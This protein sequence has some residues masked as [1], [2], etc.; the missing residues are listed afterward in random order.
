MIDSVCPILQRAHTIY[1]ATHISPDGDAIGSALGLALALGVLGKRCTVACADPAPA[2]VSFLPGS[3]MIVPQSPTTQDVIV[4]VDTG[5]TGRLG[6]LY[7]PQAFSRRT[8]INIDHHITNARF[9][10]INIID[11]QSAAVGEMIYL[12]VQALG[13]PLNS[14]IATCLLTA[15][16]TDTIGFRTSSTTPR[17]LHAA[18]ALMEAGAPLS[19][20][21]RQSFESRPLP[22]LRVWGSVL[23]S[24]QI[25]DGI[26]WAAVPIPVLQQFGVKENEIKGLVNVMRGTQGAIVAALLMESSD[27]N[28]KVEF[29]SNGHVNVADVAIALG[30][31]GHRAASG[32]TLPGPLADAEQ[33]TL[34]E[35]RKHIRP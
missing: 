19:D 4:V 3:K 32:C 25:R 23:S 11:P 33:R 20:I 22:V 29:R 17:T 27:G 2:S 10:T 14:M 9:G 18:A 21:V 34:A 1:I 5:D 13:V 28:V 31:G 35:I 26:A 8:V 30:G 6:S 24:F 12:L 15:M 7:T 16:V